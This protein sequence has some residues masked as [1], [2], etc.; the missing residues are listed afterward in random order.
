MKIKKS[1]LLFFVDGLGIGERSEHNPLTF[2]KDE[3][4]IAFFKN[5][6]T[7]VIESGIMT[8]TDAQ[9]GISGR[10]QSAS[11]QT[12]ILTGINAPAT[13]GFHKNGFPNRL[14]AELL[15][16][17]SVFLKLKQMKVSDLVF[18]NAYTPQ[19]FESE[20][21]WKSATTLAVEAAQLPFRTIEDLKAR[22]ALYHDFTN[23]IL[24][25]RGFDV[26][27][28]S[29]SDAAQ[30]LASLT[31]ENSFVLYEHFITDL[32]GHAQDLKKAI[33][34]LSQ[35]SEFLVEL[36]KRID[37]DKTTVILTS[38]HGNIEDLSIRTHTLNNVPTVIWGRKK[39]Q[40]AAKIKN[41]TDITPAIIELLRDE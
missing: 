20:P 25:E 10:P 9:L 8:I 39:E 7:E 33:G 18:A 16:K 30:I 13:L 6:E 32:I 29:A 3:S 31:Y 35:L 27:L 40:V 14:L 17:H 23:Q 28:F 36:L 41:L 37:S 4:P 15:R 2:I 22:G 19:F 21:R 5:E 11:G 38:D 26:P 1:V 24:L 34:H 12:T